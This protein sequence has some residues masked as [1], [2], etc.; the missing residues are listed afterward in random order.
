MRR[1]LGE[2]SAPHDLAVPADALDAAVTDEVV[3]VQVL[4]VVVRA[5]AQD[6]E[7]LLPGGRAADLELLLVIDGMAA[8]AD[9][10]ERFGGTHLSVVVCL[11][12]F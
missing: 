12:G 2:S 3:D 10:A 7:L 6:R 4:V 9:P 11:Y 1:L 8:L 5:V